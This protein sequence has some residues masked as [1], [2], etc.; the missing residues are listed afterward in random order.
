MDEGGIIPLHRSEN[1]LWLSAFHPIKASDGKVVAILEAD[2]EFSEFK[3]MV[4]NQYLNR[5]IVMLLIIIIFFIFFALYTRKILR[6]EALQK[7]LLA[8]QKRIIEF[9]NKDIMDSIHYALKIQTAMLPTYSSFENHFTDS[10]ILYQSK[11]VVAGDFYWLEE[12]EDDIFIAVADCTGHG[13]PGA[14]L[15]I[16]CANALEKVICEM[17]VSDPGK[18][19]DEVREIVINFLTKGDHEMNDGMDIALCK[20]NRKTYSMCYSGAYNPVYIVRGDGMIITE[21]CKQPVG[22]FLHQKSFKSTWHNLEK[23][24]AL[25]LFTDGF[26]DQFGGPRKKKFKYKQFRNLILSHARKSMAEQKH[27]MLNTF[28]TWRGS[29]EQIDDVCVVGVQI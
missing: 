3:K 11:D 23:G 15:S 1:G 22:R 20:I 2:I 18:I 27:I 24:D 9:K 17:K 6:E 14:I 26:A 8:N 7:R 10:F 28:H 19:L 21:P 5:A 16:I 29:E 12:I 13:V 25:Y 4:N